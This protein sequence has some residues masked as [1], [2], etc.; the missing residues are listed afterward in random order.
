[1]Q[2][3][4][5]FDDFLAICKSAEKPLKLS[6][7]LPTHST[8]P[9]DEHVNTTPDLKSLPKLIVREMQTYLREYTFLPET[10]KPLGDLLSSDVVDIMVEA[11]MM[12][13]LY[14]IRSQVQAGTKRSYMQAILTA[15]IE[16][17]EAPHKDMEVCKKAIACP[18][19]Q[20]C[21]IGALHKIFD[22]KKA[23]DGDLRQRILCFAEHLPDHVVYLN[24]NSAILENLG[25]LTGHNKV[26]VNS[27]CF[28][29]G[30]SA[31]MGIVNPFD[32]MGGWGDTLRLLHVITVVTHG[33]THS[34]HAKFLQTSAS[35][36]LLTSNQTSRIRIWSSGDLSSS[37]CLV[38]NP[39]GG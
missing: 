5:T 27:Q 26:F 18:F 11:R 10:L 9:T 31:N 22:V 4:T 32:A 8:A 7:I 3:E 21:M 1:M 14:S 37:A 20:D 24:I 17:V 2:T 15:N 34:L 35:P 28:H 16:K 38:A 33:L 23:S 13:L 6:H 19:I 30:W 29:P 39:R 12:F 25:G 36:H